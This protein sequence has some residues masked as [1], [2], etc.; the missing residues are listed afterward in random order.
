MELEQVGISAVTLAELEY[1][2]AKSQYPER[3]SVALVEFLTPFRVL[4]FDQAAAHEY[5][6]IRRS[7]EEKGQPIGPMDLLIAA[8][9]IANNLVLVTNNEREFERVPLPGLENWTNE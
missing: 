3:N 1:G 5:G 7:L 6:Q 8:H 2:V 9:A 4:D